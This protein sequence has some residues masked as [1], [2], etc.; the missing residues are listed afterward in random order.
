MCTFFL[1][2]WIHGAPYYAVG[3]RSELTGR[4][5]GGFKSGLPDLPERSRCT[6][7][8]VASLARWISINEEGKGSAWED[9]RGWWGAR[10]VRVES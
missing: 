1:K 9:G 5:V 3:D 2:L 8:A 6:D 4:C 10:T 7:C